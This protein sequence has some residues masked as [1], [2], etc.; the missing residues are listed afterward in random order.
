MT[1]SSAPAPLDIAGRRRSPATLPGYHAGR[2][3]R[4][5]GQHY[6]A[7]PP[8]PQRGVST[9]F[10]PELDLS[11]VTLHTREVAGSNPAAPI[12]AAPP[13]ARLLRQADGMDGVVSI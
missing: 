7:Y 4:N 3:P 9:G 12:H 13:V 5:K 10:T 2:P 6:P 11:L 1:V 8:S